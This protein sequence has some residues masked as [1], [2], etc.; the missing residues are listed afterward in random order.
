MQHWEN[1]QP[2]N[3]IVFSEAQ[4]D[5]RNVQHWESQQPAN[6]VVVSE[7]RPDSRK[8]QNWESHV[9]AKHVVAS[10][11][12]EQPK[13][14]KVEQKQFHSEPAKPMKS[15]QLSNIFFPPLFTNMVV[16]PQVKSNFL[17]LNDYEVTLLFSKL[18]DKPCL[19]LDEIGTIDYSNF[20][21]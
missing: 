2:A 13:N 16:L 7:S 12:P 8:V 5:S 18:L 15:N 17:Q 19:T 1:Q 21:Q 10:Q 6:Q 11:R 20:G 14:W 4:P 9:P 3:H